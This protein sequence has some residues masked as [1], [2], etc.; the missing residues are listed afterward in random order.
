MLSC[1]RSVT[2]IR[3]K[4]VFMYTIIGNTKLLKKKF[5]FAYSS[6]SNFYLRAVTA[7]SLNFIIFLIRKRKLLQKLLESDFLIVL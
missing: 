3:E 1:K 5:K 7:A 6:L 4:G 2:H